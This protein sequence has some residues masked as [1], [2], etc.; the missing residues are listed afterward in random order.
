MTQQ[1]DFFGVPLY[2][3]LVG[4]GKEAH[5]RDMFKFFPK[6]IKRLGLERAKAEGLIT[7]EELLRLKAERASEELKFYLSKGSKKK[8]N[9]FF[10]GRK[11]NYDFNDS[12]NVCFLFLARTQ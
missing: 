9:E 3:K 1:V 10:N 2:P 7:E 8:K 12:G 11:N 5:P 6:K 4:S